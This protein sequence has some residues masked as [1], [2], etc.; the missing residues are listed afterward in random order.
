MSKTKMAALFLIASLLLFI[1][2]SCVLSTA[3]ADSHVLNH[4]SRLIIRKTL[5]NNGGF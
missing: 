3:A 1:F 4:L 5:S 2:F